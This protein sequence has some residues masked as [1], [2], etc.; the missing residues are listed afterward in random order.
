M[1][2]PSHTWETPRTGSLLVYMKSRFHMALL[3][4]LA[5]L[6][7]PLIFLSPRYSHVY[8]VLALLVRVLS[9]SHADS[10][11]FMTFHKK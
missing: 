11:L 7:L 9:Y 3:K 4:P 5:P 1:P 6:Q 2:L 10:F 8:Q